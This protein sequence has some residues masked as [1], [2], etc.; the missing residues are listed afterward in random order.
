MCFSF[1]FELEVSSLPASRD[2]W[3]GNR[4]NGTFEEKLFR[5]TVTLVTHRVL[6]QMA[7]MNFNIRSESALFRNVPVIFW[8]SFDHFFYAMKIV[9]QQP[10]KNAGHRKPAAR[11][12][13][14]PVSGVQKDDG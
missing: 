5:D 10:K 6:N 3:A 2:V 13:N 12:T 4:L 7:T 14:K 8:M 9:G 11:N 1:F